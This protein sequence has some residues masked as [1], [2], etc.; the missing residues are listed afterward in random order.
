MKGVAEGGLKGVGGGVVGWA[1]GR[2]DAEGG[3][4]G[5]EAVGKGRIDGDAGGKG[6]SRR[7]VGDGR[8]AVEEGLERGGSGEVAVAQDGD[9]LF[10]AEGLEN[11]AGASDGQ[12]GDAAAVAEEGVEGFEGR[13]GMGA[14]NGGD[15]ES[16]GGEESSAEFPVAQVGG[17]EDGFAGFGREGGEAGGGSGIE[18][19]AG[20]GGGGG[21]E[22]DEIDEKTGVVAEGGA[23]GTAEFARSGVGG[24]QDDGKVV[25]DGTAGGAVQVPGERTGDPGDG[26]SERGGE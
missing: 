11:I 9:D 16:E 17:E 19:L 22:T 24:G 1:E 21:T 2:E 8:G 23:G 20:E 10:A 15:G 5:R 14:D 25:D 7:T 6:Q 13:R 3:G 18:G 26:K 12:E 4:A